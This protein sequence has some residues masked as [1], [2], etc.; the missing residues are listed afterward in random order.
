MN[1]MAQLQRYQ[2]N[3][4]DAQRLVV[5]YDDFRADNKAT[6]RKIFRFLHVDDTVSFSTAEVNRSTRVR[7]KRIMKLMDA[8]SEGRGTG[9]ATFKTAAE[10]ITTQR[11]RRAAQDVV[12]RHVVYGKPHPP[13]HDLVVELRRR[14]KP[15]VEA[16]TAYLGHDL[17][18]LWG[19]NAIL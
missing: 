7:A 17:T 2:D 9:F 18:Q 8:A 1:Y 13:E 6:L 19:Y 5:I 10:T 15:E 3:F 14:Y 16:L 4:P 12:R 11:V